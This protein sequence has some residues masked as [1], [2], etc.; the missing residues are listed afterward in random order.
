MQLKNIKTIFAKE[1]KD[2]L[3][4]RRTL[5]FMLVVPIVAMPLLMTGISRLMISQVKKI[6]AQ[7]SSLVVQNVQELPG[8]LQD[9]LRTSSQFK[10]IDETVYG[11]KALDSLKS[12][13]L[14]LVMVVPP[15]FRSAIELESPTDVEIY[16][17]KA[18]DMS[19][20]AEDKLTALLK[21]YKDR[22]IAARLV[23]RN[24]STELLT[25]FEEVR[26]SIASPQ[27]LA[28]QT[29]GRMLPY[30]FILMCFLG[31]MYPAID[32]CVGEKERG[33]LETLLVAPATRGEFVLGKYGVILLAGM[34]AGLLCMVSMTY[35]LNN[36][37]VG[38]GDMAAAMPKIEVNLSMIALILM[39][40]IPLAGIFAAILLSVSIF[41]KS[42]KEAQGYMGFLNMFLI[43]PAFISFLPGVELNWTLSVIPVMN[44]SLIVRDAIAGE[45]HWQFIITAFVSTFV[46]ASLALWFAKTWFER[47]EVL[48]RM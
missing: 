36:M 13:A 10:L 20:A 39:I 2:T 21:R 42:A 44:T 18:D 5:I 1:L 33:T 15:N 32:L 16:Y 6:E 9:T 45:V 26:N 34:V 25:P 8:D 28:G 12:G 43:F 48:F 31:A 3:R 35:S 30:F 23:K 29:F 47:E 40:V 7:V 27:K 41:A 19:N 11:D 37:M 17:D 38:M 24:I 4:D 22:T 46:L 14:D